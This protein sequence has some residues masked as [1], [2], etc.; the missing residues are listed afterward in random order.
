MQRKKAEQGHKVFIA[1]AILDYQKDFLI[2][3]LCPLYILK[4]S[5]TDYVLAE[6]CHTS[7]QIKTQKRALQLLNYGQEKFFK[8]TCLWIKYIPDDKVTVY[9]IVLIYLFIYFSQ[10]YPCG[11][12]LRAPLLWKAK[13]AAIY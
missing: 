6:K 2:A 8:Q 11:C 12:G 3:S 9:K 5:K 4:I 1:A 13:C 7:L 10:N